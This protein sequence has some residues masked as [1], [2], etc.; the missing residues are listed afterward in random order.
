VCA[1]GKQDKYCK[2][3]REKK[4]QFTNLNKQ[5]NRGV[6]KKDSLIS[7]CTITKKLVILSREERRK[8]RRKKKKNLPNSQNDFLVTD[9]CR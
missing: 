6:Y 7:K 4:R 3:G 1:R 8:R 9:E 2:K 5:D